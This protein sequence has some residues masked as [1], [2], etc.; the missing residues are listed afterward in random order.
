MAMIP[1]K[2]KHVISADSLSFNTMAVFA[3]TLLI[4]SHLIE[5]FVHQRFVLPAV[6]FLLLIM[7]YLLFPNSLNFGKNGA[8]RML[9]CC[10]YYLK[11][12]KE[13]YYL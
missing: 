2:S 11:K 12:I 1:K 8:Q 4:G 7:A 6:V 13:R 10:R 5:N 3:A 9:M